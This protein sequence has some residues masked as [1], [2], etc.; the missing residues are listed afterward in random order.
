MLTGT[1]LLLL[2]STLRVATAFC[3]PGLRGIERPVAAGLRLLVNTFRF[4]SRLEIK[5]RKKEE[6]EKE[7]KRKK[8]KETLNL[9][10]C[11]YCVLGKTDK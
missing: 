1:L 2:L 10:F 11:T 4:K 7:K 3:P 6:K 5:K 8:R 9:L